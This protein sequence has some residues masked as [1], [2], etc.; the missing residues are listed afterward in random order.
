MKKL[1][2]VIL[3]EEIEPYLPFWERLGGERT[4]EV[5]E[6]DRLGFAAVRLGDVEIMYQSRASVAADVPALAEGPFTRD[7]IGLFIE[8]EDLD[9]VSRRLGSEAEVIVPERRTFYGARELGV[10]TPCGTIVTFAEFG[11][12][13]MA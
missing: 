2:P 9:G 12:E 1:T 8:V 11:N 4:I 10:R 5:P 3:V 13:E 7:G 6:G